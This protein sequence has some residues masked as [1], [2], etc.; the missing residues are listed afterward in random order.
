MV[1]PLSTKNVQSKS[2]GETLV[3]T[4]AFNCRYH[5]IGQQRY[6]RSMAILARDRSAF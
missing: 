6:S 5:S 4:L 3:I 2:D 1:K